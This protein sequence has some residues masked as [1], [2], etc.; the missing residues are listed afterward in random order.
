MFELT[1]ADAPLIDPNPYAGVSIFFACLG[2]CGVL[3]GVLLHQDRPLRLALNTPGGSIARGYSPQSSLESS[4]APSPITS[5]V[6][7]ATPSPAATRNVSPT[8]SV[9]GG[10]VGGGGVG[11]GGVGGGS[12]ESAG[13]VGSSSSGGGG[14]GSRSGS[15]SGLRVFEGEVHVGGVLLGAP[16]EQGRVTWSAVKLEPN[17]PA[18]PPSR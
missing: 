7:S 6:A 15:E 5:P 3:C 8:P 11:G 2:M 13:G 16:A 17:A 1:T 9:G 18:F 12:G 4:M 14:A 10:G